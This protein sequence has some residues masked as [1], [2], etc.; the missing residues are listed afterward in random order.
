MGKSWLRARPQEQG[1]AS[2]R[3]PFEDS[4]TTGLLASEGYYAIA[5]VKVSQL[6]GP[7][8]LRHPANRSRVQARCGSRKSCAAGLDSISFP[9]RITAMRVA[10]NSSLAQ[11][12]PP[13]DS[14]LQMIQSVPRPR[15]VRLRIRGSLGAVAI[16]VVAVI[17]F[18]AF[19]VATRSGNRAKE[20]FLTPRTPFG[21]TSK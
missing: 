9:A 6:A 4:F 15:L 8:Y 2:V 21:M 5:D 11:T 1:L 16:V 20:G 14:S 3:L 13:L 10:S 12:Q 17:A 19:L 7:G 18:T